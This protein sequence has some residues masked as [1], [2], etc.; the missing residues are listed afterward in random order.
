[1]FLELQFI[2][3]FGFPGELLSELM[4]GHISILVQSKLKLTCLTHVLFFY[5]PFVL[6][7]YLHSPLI[8]F[9]SHI[10]SIVSSH[11]LDKALR[12]VFKHHLD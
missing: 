7:I 4:I 6:T 2:L 9:F 5:V 1:M 3:Y 12:G 8:L 10:L 11:K